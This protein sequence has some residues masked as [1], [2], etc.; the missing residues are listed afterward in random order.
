MAKRAFGK[1][2]Q[3]L[4]IHGPPM[5][6]TWHIAMQGDCVQPSGSQ[7]KPEA[8]LQRSHSA[9]TQTTATAIARQDEVIAWRI[10]TPDWSEG[11]ALLLFT[12]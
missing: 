2:S 5:S 1:T 9:A 7:A 12:N 3:K 8:T 11:A 6:A 10:V 4:T